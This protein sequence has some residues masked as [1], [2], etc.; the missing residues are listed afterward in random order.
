MVATEVGVAA[1]GDGLGAA[2]HE[3][4]QHLL[5]GGARL[6]HV[7]D[8][9][10]RDDKEADEH[11]DAQAAVGDGQPVGAGHQ[12][13]GV[14]HAALA[15]VAGNLAVAV[16]DLVEAARRAVVRHQRGGVALGARHAGTALHGAEVAR[17]AL[18]VLLGARAVLDPRLPLELLAVEAGR[19]ALSARVRDGVAQQALVAQP[20]V[21]GRPLLV[22]T[23]LRLRRF[24]ALARPHVHVRK[25]QRH[26]HTVAAARPVIPRSVQQ[27]PLRS[28]RR[29]DDDV[30]HLHGRLGE[31]KRLPR[32]A[33][34]PRVHHVL[35]GV[36]V[37]GHH[38]QCAVVA[39]LVDVRAL[40]DLEPGQARVAAEVRV[41]LILTLRE[42]RAHVPR[43][44]HEA[45]RRLGAVERAPDVRHTVKVEGAVVITAADWATSGILLRRTKV[46]PDT[47]L[48]E[49]DHRSDMRALECSGLAAALLLLALLRLARLIRRS[50]GVRVIVVHVVD[51]VGNVD[52]LQ[53]LHLLKVALAVRIPPVVRQRQGVV[54]A[55]S[56][57][58]VDVAP[59]RAVALV[60]HVQEDGVL[61]RV[62]DGVRVLLDLE[63][64]DGTAEPAAPVG[65]DGERDLRL[66]VR[67]DLGDKEVLG[68]EEEAVA[69]L[70]EALL[71]LEQVV[72]AHEVDALVPVAEALVARLLVEHGGKDGV[73]GQAVRLAA[74][75]VVHPVE[76]D[77]VV[78]EELPGL[79]KVAGD[80]QVLVAVALSVRVVALGRH[81]GRHHAAV[82]LGVQLHLVELHL[83]GGQLVRLARI[84][85]RPRHLAHAHKEEPV[86][87]HRAQQDGLH[88]RHDAVQRIPAQR[89]V[90]VHGL[91]QPRHL[92]CPRL[93]VVR[94]A[95]HLLLVR[96]QEDGLAVLTRPD[97]IIHIAIDQ[98]LG[99]RDRV[100]IRLRGRRLRVSARICSL[101]RILRQ[102]ARC[103]GDARHQER[104][105]L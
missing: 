88:P 25:V 102:N 49:S 52:A 66:A 22:V 60:V 43:G 98:A 18:P 70:D 54:E 16:G 92:V 58:N 87:V 101:C 74:L 28:G 7:G 5:R 64:Q 53:T 37:V 45:H 55:D 62:Q 86:R 56:V 75:Q 90:R 42:V 27:E 72:G 67:V 97:Q 57:G 78:G 103:Q 44:H 77:H 8:E 47:T 80:E 100:Y 91:V 36:L 15:R 71:R 79:P 93:A 105:G 40:A 48:V 38:D 94:A 13:R 24:L 12:H 19:V 6:V 81:G 59:S 89:W 95:V 34:V 20:P 23:A 33:L 9:A 85:S 29:L 39:K 83:V 65:G 11:E 1:V 50:L 14:V 76:L 68:G 99:H 3:P 32:Q 96:Q 46:A 30:L 61:R 69:M 31:L 26:H 51:V 84:R 2:G 82:V 104:A 10:Q 41:D 73:R 4:A 21:R 63:G 17:V 35:R